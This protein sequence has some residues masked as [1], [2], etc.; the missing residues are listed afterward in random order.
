MS[1]RTARAM[2]V[3]E[4]IGVCAIAYWPWD[5]AP[6]LGTQRTLVTS[7]FLLAIA[8]G[9]IVHFRRYGRSETATREPA[10]DERRQYG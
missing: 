10:G 5:A 4:M 3:V 9:S 6:R 1:T 2:L 7:V 8:A